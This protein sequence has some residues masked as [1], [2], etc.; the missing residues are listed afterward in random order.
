MIGSVGQVRRGRRI[1]VVD[2]SVRNP[3]FPMTAHRTNLV[4]AEFVGA[5]S[6]LQRPSWDYSVAP[7]ATPSCV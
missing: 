3:F 4:K 7:A 1:V 5:R 2:Q 6:T